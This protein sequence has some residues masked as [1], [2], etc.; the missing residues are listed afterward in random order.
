M[1]FRHKLDDFINLHQAA[2]GMDPELSRPADG[3]LPRDLS[4]ASR[5]PVT[6]FEFACRG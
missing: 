6:S 2:N 1:S 3:P 4:R 5:I